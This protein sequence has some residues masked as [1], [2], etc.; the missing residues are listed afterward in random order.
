MGD[1]T[2]DVDAVGSRRGVVGMGSTSSRNHVLRTDYAVD[3]DAKLIIGTR[4][5]SNRCKL[6]ISDTPGM[7]VG[8]LFQNCKPVIVGG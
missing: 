4:P 3:G 6:R 5:F 7:F 2:N 8:A 1:G